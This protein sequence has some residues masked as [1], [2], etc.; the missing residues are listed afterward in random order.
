[1]RTAG[2]QKAEE[3]AGPNKRFGCNNRGNHRILEVSPY[4]II[5][6]ECRLKRDIRE[7]YDI[8]SIAESQDSIFHAPCVSYYF[9]YFPLHSY[10]ANRKLMS[11]VISCMEVELYG[12]FERI[13]S[14]M[15]L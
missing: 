4:M 12:V 1:M 10:V 9:S 7:L 11:S 15:F 8:F 6:R 3:N 13:L 2:P 14:K 5:R